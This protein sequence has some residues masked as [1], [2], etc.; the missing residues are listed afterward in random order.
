MAHF[1][2]F[3]NTRFVFD[4]AWVRLPDDSSAS[5]KENA[6]NSLWATVIKTPDEDVSAG[7]LPADEEKGKGAVSF[8]ALA[9][10]SFPAEKNAL[11]FVEM[12]DGRA[13][14]AAARS[15]LPVPDFDR[16]GDADSLA[17]LAQ[18]FLQDNP[19]ARV[20]GNTDRFEQAQILDLD[21][22]IGGK[23]AK[24]L[25]ARAAVRKIRSANYLTYFLVFVLVAFGGF[26]FY[27]QMES[28]RKAEEAARMAAE[29]QKQNP[30]IL[31]AQALPQAIAAQGMPAMEAVRLLDSMK[32]REMSAGGW[33]VSSIK[34]S[35]AGCRVSWVKQIITAAFDDLVRV[36]GKDGLTLQSA[37]AAE[38]FI[39][40]EAAPAVINTAVLPSEQDAWLK[41]ASP[42]QRLGSGV[43][44]T[45]T[46]GTAFSAG[47]VTP[48]GALAKCEMRYSG[49]L[50]VADFMRNLPEWALVREFNIGIADRSPKLDATIVFF[51]R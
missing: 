19:D 33:R 13:F 34:C 6:A 36:I 50:W 42:L 39:P 48:P 2:N 10:M 38:K 44:L 35:S 7:Y 8:A 45:V 11:I 31:Y 4:L 9:A 51:A 25:L 27:D 1:A 37:G 14:M 32:N 18:E 40:F 41:L 16:L 5:V 29:Q 30:A 23:S 17:R 3:G 12:D 49:S 20:F 15:G 26:V 43:T 22:F 21:A 24:R 28:K 46:K 47:G